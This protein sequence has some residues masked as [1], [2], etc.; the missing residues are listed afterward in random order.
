MTEFVDAWENLECGSDVAL[1]NLLN[2][3]VAAQ[4]T[5]VDAYNALTCQYCNNNDLTCQASPRTCNYNEDAEAPCYCSGQ[6][7]P[8]FAATIA[9]NQFHDAFGSSLPACQPPAT[10]DTLFETV[11]FLGTVWN[12]ALVVAQNAFTD[13]YHDLRCQY[14]NVVSVCQF[15]LSCSGIVPVCSCGK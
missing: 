6:I 2:T 1:T 7:E 12:T 9:F 3:A 15:P 10:V 11:L 13:A 5:M 8:E 4:A 14:C